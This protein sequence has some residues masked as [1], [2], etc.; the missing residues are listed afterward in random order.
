MRT[1]HSYRKG[2]HVYHVEW[3]LR[4]CPVGD[5]LQGQES[6]DTHEEVR[7]TVI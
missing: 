3:A 4:V 5:R 6:G 1:G 7:K 2:Y